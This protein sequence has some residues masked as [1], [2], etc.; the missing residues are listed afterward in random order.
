MIILASCIQDSV[1][2]CVAGENYRISGNA[3]V[4]NFH[5]T[6]GIHYFSLVK[7]SSI[8]KPAP[9]VTAESATLNAGK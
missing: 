3:L 5:E 2:C 8:N 7:L 9:H 6:S 1:I 4:D